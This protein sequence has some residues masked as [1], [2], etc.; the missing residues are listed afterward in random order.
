L[1]DSGNATPERDT[2][3]IGWHEGKNNLKIR[4]GG[5]AIMPPMCGRIERDMSYILIIGHGA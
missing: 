4:A 3:T 2:T 5:L 1:A